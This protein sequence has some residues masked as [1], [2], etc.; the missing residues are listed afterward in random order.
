M[1]VGSRP[2]TGGPGRRELSRLLGARRAAHKAR[3]RAPDHS[4]PQLRLVAGVMHPQRPL[5]VVDHRRVE[6]HAHAIVLGPPQ[7]PW[8]PA[9]RDR[10][11]ARGEKGWRRGGRDCSI[12]RPRARRARRSCNRAR[13]GFVERL[14]RPPSRCGLVAGAISGAAYAPRPAPSSRPP[15]RRVSRP[16]SAPGR[17]VVRDGAAEPSTCAKFGARGGRRSALQTTTVKRAGSILRSTRP[18]TRDPWPRRAR[19]S[20]RQRARGQPSGKLGPDQL[21][22]AVGDP[23]GAQ[24]A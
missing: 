2:T 17:Q 23:P 5:P 22:Q 12:E 15:G 13:S 21:D 14:S 6:A 7:A 11:R 20:R 1:D 19:R 18:G 9:R 10:C 3:P 24:R 16:R 8:P 4:P